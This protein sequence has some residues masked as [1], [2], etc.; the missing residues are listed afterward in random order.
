ML[1]IRIAKKE[2][3]FMNNKVYE[4]V[5]QQILDMLEKAE[6]EEKIHW[7]K[8]WRGGSPLPKAYLADEKTFYRGINVVINEPSEYITFTELQKM[9]EKDSSIKIRKGCHTHTVYYF[10]FMEKKNEDGTVKTDKDGNPIKIPY[11]KFYKVYD[12]N[13]IIGLE[14]RMKNFVKNEH[15]LNAN[16]KKAELYIKVFCDLMNIDMVVK[17]GSSRAYFNPARN[18]ITVPAKSQYAKEDIAEFYS[19]N[20]HEI[21]HALD[22]ILRLTTDTQKI[23]ITDGEEIEP[24]EDAYST[25]ELFAEI[26]SQMLAHRLMIDAESSMKNSCEYVRGWI[27][28]IKSE[29][30]SFVVNI[31]SKAGRACDYF[32]EQVEKE[33]E[34]YN[35]QEA[36]IQGDG[37][38]IHIAENSDSDFEYDVYKFDILTEKLKFIDGGIIERGEDIN[39]LM[40]ALADVTSE[41]CISEQALHSMDIEDFVDLLAGDVKYEEVCR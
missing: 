10:N 23:K 36:V 3:F 18:S 37:K 33:L 38:I 26:C 15:T 5:Q 2:V 20:L 32:F 19:T 24:L 29:K 41:W 14:S 9:R 27:Q 8:P 11:L 13:D 12:I 21:S 25:G 28:K 39:N 7:I 30:S 22:H 16:M 34:K 1:F 6:K 35:V 40:D 31:A 17:E 4:I